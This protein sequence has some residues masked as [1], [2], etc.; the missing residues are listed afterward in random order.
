MTGE[1]LSLA[2]SAVMRFRADATTAS[3][4]CAAGYKPAPPTVVHLLDPTLVRGDV[5]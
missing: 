5:R 3:E 1:A 2:Q 4:R